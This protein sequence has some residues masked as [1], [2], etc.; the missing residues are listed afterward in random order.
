MYTPCT[1]IPTTDLSEQVSF[2]DTQLWLFHGV[3]IDYSF[4]NYCN[5]FNIFHVPNW[6]DTYQEM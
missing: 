1:V 4:L 3:L 2:L 5:L 6:K